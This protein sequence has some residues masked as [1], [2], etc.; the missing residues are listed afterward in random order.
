[1]ICSTIVGFALIWIFNAR[2]L[3]SF[4]PVVYSGALGRVNIARAL[5]KKNKWAKCRTRIVRLRQNKSMHTVSVRVFI[6]SVWASHLSRGTIDHWFFLFL[7]R[8]EIHSFQ[9]L[10][11]PCLP[12][13]FGSRHIF[14][15][16]C[17]VTHFHHL[18]VKQYWP[19]QMNAIFS[20]F[21]AEV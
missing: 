3:F 16:F 13:R 7:F 6:R 14:L 12:S 4:F 9:V 18:L 19:V 2:K 8:I 1:M 15:P 11:T 17:V 20:F 10:W 5:E 21:S